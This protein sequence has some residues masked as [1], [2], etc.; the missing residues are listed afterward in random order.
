MDI[1][2]MERIGKYELRLWKNDYG[3]WVVE[4]KG[5]DVDPAEQVQVFERLIDAYSYIDDC[6]NYLVRF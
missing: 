5:P 1:S 4:L 6:R 2:T 3:D